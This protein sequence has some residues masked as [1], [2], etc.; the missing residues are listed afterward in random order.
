MTTSLQRGVRSRLRCTSDAS[1]NAVSLL[2]ATLAEEKATD[3]K[4]TL[5]A[6]GGGNSKAAAK[7]K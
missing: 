3:E 1:V 5:I 6:K 2:Q 7:S 4:L